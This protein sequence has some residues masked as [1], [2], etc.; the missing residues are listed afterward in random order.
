[1]GLSNSTL[2]GAGQEIPSRL[3]E[4]LGQAG[5]ER[6]VG[7]GE[8]LFSQGDEGGCLYLVRSGSLELYLILEGEREESLGLVKAGEVLGAQEY[9]DGGPRSVSARAV[10]DTRVVE[11]REGAFEEAAEKQPLLGFELLSIVATALLSR[12]SM[13][14]QLHRRE[15]LRGIELSGAQSCDFRIILRET[16]QLEVSLTD[17]EGVFSGS[18]ISVSGCQGGDVLILLNGEG[19]LI[20]IPFHSIA[21]I[22]AQ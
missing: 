1:M 18:V 17:E 5:T 10:E 2:H 21:S 19:D 16:F 3:G 11:I 7:V 12:L 8:V 15:M 6:S 20:F 14:N 22:R 4:F 9:L 13:T